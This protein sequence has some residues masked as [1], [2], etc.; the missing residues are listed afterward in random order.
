MP[1]GSLPVQALHRGTR[2]RM[3]TRFPIMRDARF[4][5]DCALHIAQFAHQ[6]GVLAYYRFHTSGSVSTRDPIDFVRECVRNALEIEQWWREHGDI[7]EPRRSALLN[8][9]LHMARAS[10]GSDTATFDI[11]YR[12]LERIQPGFVPLRLKSLNLIYRAID[13]RRAEGVAGWYRTVKQP[14]RRQTS[15]K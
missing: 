14:L 13:Y 4:A 3:N 9:Y 7:T 5:L 1:T 15:T 12:A 6:P 2:R 8:V 10:Y 11:A